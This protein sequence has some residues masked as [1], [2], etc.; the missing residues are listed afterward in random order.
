[1]KLLLIA[2]M[3]SLAS[4]IHNVDRCQCVRPGADETTH[5]SGSEVI[6]VIE[7]KVYKRMRGTVYDAAG[8]LMPDTLVEV[9]DHPESLLLKYPARER[10]QRKQRRIAA[11]KT[12]EDGKFCFKGLR[13]GKYELRV[14]RDSGW[15]VTQV[16]LGLD[17]RGRRSTA[18][19]IEV[20][21]QVGR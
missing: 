2:L 3:L 11:C 15:N 12:G 13:P 7:K 9:F 19:E 21:M 4:G 18:A 1:M 16:Y 6:T 14:S 8:F 10:A 20:Y 5:W 17:P